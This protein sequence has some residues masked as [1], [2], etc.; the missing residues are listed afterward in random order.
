MYIGTAPGNADAHVHRIIV[1]VESV[2][3]KIQKQA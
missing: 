3:L 1:A 2:P